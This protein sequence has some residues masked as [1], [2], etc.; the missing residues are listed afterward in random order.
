MSRYDVTDRELAAAL[1]V[2]AG[3]AGAGIVRVFD[4][5]DCAGLVARRRTRVAGQPHA[6][7][8]RTRSAPRQGWAG[9]TGCRALKRAV[10]ARSAVLVVVLVAANEG[11]AVL[12]VVLA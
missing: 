9:P 4:G 6:L 5:P 11:A 8:N 1:A 7:L 3:G 12:G 2:L 10:G